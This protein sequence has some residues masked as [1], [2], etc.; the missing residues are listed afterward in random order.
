LDGFWIEAREIALNELF[1]AG[2]MHL[3]A[4]GWHIGL[5]IRDSEQLE[6][7]TSKVVN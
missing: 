4:L 7:L 2:K 3:D 1:L 6:D 5:E